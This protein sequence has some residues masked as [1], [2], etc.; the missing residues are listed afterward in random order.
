MAN[1]TTEEEIKISEYALTVNEFNKPKIL[2]NNAA[3]CAKI[4]EIALLVP[5]TYPTRPNMGLGLVNNY[6]YQ[7]TADLTM[8]KTAFEDQI[9]TYLPSITDIEISIYPVNKE[10]RFA[11]K[12]DDTMFSLVLDK[13]TKTLMSL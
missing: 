1:A 7:S 9:R 10:I 8:L 3:I 12:A 2:V 5:G 6:R 13:D 11:I 4:I